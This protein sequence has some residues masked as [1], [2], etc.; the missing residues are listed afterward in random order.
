MSRPRPVHRY[1]VLVALALAVSM[2]AIA[3]QPALATS[4]RTISALL[5]P[6]QVEHGTRMRLP[7]PRVI[8]PF[9]TH[10]RPRTGNPGATPHRSYPR[11]HTTAA[12]VSGGSF[13]GGGEGSCCTDPPLIGGAV[14]ATQFVQVD[15][16]NL[17]VFDRTTGAS[18]KQT[19][20]TNF[21]P[22]GVQARIVYDFAIARWYY[23]SG[24]STG[25]SVC[26]AI[27]ASADATGGWY[28]YDI[29]LVAPTGGFS[30]NVMVGYDED[31]VF[32]TSDSYDS[33]GNYAY[34]IVEAVSKGVLLTDSDGLVAVYVAADPVVP[35]MV[36]DQSSL[37]DYFLGTEPSGTA[38]ILYQGTQLDHIPTG[39]FQ[40]E[41]VSVPA[42]SAPPPAAQP[43][44]SDTLNAGNGSFQGPSTQIG[45]ALFNVHGI[46]VN[47]HPGIRWYQINPAAATLTNYGRVYDSSTTDDFDPSMVAAS[48]NGT[49]SEYFAW[50]STD[51]RNPTASNHHAPE[52]ALATRAAGDPLNVPRGTHSGPGTNYDPAAGEN[53]WGD[54]QVSIDPNAGGGCPAGDRAFAIAPLGKATQLWVA[55]IWR[56]GV[57]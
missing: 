45:N 17:T 5:K 32:W 29:P 51:T 20:L 3:A 4:A 27:S 33:S 9:G 23:A 37:S 57:C 16:R 48:V 24:N 10:H 47:G 18:L 8:H 43:G 25:K 14:S 46:S 6:G 50:T 53:G 19:R 30:Q 7:R 22:G 13:T 44:T 35:P 12:L 11:A 39:T 38:L 52:M 1:R 41:D 26:V 49:L 34:S 56:Y 2:S 36:N 54:S 55:H 21:C 40:R 42:Y 28:L 15:T 31:S